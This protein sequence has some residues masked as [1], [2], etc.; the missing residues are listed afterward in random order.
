MRL[1]NQ[2]PPKYW[3]CLRRK[4]MKYLIDF[5]E[6]PMEGTLLVRVPVVEL[7]KS[8]YPWRRTIAVNECLGG[9]FKD[10]S[11]NALHP[12]F[13]RLRQA[14]LQTIGIM[15]FIGNIGIGP[16]ELIMIGP[17]PNQVFSQFILS[18]CVFIK[19][20]INKGELILQ[21]MNLSNRCD[22]SMYRGT[23]VVS[24]VRK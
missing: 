19:C 17:G 23:Q 4:I 5:T 24:I 14:Q 22:K 7:A 3:P 2:N 12:I 10:A 6:S 18:V 16:G 1:R 15:R 13:S 20:Q 11:R 21:Q 9:S 8:H